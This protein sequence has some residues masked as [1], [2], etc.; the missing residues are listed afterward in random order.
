MAGNPLAEVSDRLL[1]LASRARYL[2]DVKVTE[3]YL[4]IPMHLIDRLQTESKV[5]YNKKANNRKVT[6]KNSFSHR[7]QDLHIEHVRSVFPHVGLDSDLPIDA[8][9]LAEVLSG[10]LGIASLPIE[11]MRRFTY[12]GLGIYR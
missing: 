1:K 6:E 2:K 12:F 5:K 8:D 10:E 11:F 3:T 4:V 9:W 7:Q